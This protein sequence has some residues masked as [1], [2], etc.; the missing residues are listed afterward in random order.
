[1]EEAWYQVQCVSPAFLGTT[2]CFSHWVN[3]VILGVSFSSDACNLKQ[4]R[5]DTDSSF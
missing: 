3:V 5:Q 4:Y 1:M 2:L